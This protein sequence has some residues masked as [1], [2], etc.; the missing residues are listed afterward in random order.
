MSNYFYYLLASLFYQWE[1][2]PELDI[3]T[4]EL[5]DSRYCHQN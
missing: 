3:D 1:L 2:W 5:L 4:P